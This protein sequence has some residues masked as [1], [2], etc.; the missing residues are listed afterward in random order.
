MDIL[1]NKVMVFTIL[2]VIG[3][4]AESITGTIS[5]GRKNMDVF[6]VITIAT[7]TALGGGTVRDVLLGYYPLTWVAHP[8]YIIVTFIA[9]VVAMLIVQHVVRLHK[10]FLIVDALGLVTFAYIGSDIGYQI[11]IHSAYSQNFQLIGTIII[12]M[13]M[14]IITGISGGVLRD[15]LCNDVPLV[16]QAELY[17]IV[18]AIVGIL[19]T[20]TMYYHID[21]LLTALIIV[22]IGFTLRLLAIF[23]NW[24]LPKIKYFT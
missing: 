15:I 12:A 7:I 20:L 19:H 18:A 8:E 22:I 9:S 16:F 23:K 24:H 21:N 6:G 3:I 17:A 5:A 14:A 13:I 2:Y 10:L 11:A 4:A 1:A